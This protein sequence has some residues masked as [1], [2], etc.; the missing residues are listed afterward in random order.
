MAS[1]RDS[2]PPS[3]ICWGCCL[4][5]ASL[6]GRAVLE[7]CSTLTTVPEIPPLVSTPI[8]LC[9]GDN[10]YSLLMSLTG[11]TLRS[12]TVPTSTKFVQKLRKCI[13]WA[14]RKA[15]LFQQKQAWHHKFNYDKWSKAM[16][17]RTGDMVLVCVT[18]FKGQHRIQSRWK[19][20]EYVV[21]WQPYPDLP[22][23]V[24]CLIDGEGCSHTLH[25]NFLLPI[26]H[27]LEQDEGEDAVEGAGSNEHTPVSHEEDAS[28][29]DSLTGSQLESTPC[30]PSKQCEPVNLELTRLTSLDSIDE[31]FQA[32]DDML[33]PLR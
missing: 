12:I 11:L 29:A 3:L 2:T 32:Y 16:S 15:D 19:N 30:L 8:S 22:M 10:P 31:G 5:N 1:V 27:N 23:Y 17:L 24:V 28:P 4:Q 33:A 20:R 21:E 26:S 7:C 18:T 13:R 9:T 6:T 14:H 25:Q